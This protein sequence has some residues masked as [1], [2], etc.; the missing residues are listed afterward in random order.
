MLYRRRMLGEEAWGQMSRASGCLAYY[1]IDKHSRFFVKFSPHLSVRVLSTTPSRFVGNEWSLAGEPHIVHMR[2]LRFQWAWNFCE[3]NVLATFLKQERA[4][5]NGMNEKSHKCK[6]Q[7]CLQKQ[8]EQR[9]TSLA[10]E[11]MSNEGCKNEVFNSAVKHENVLSKVVAGWRNK[12]GST[13]R[14]QS[15]TAVRG[16]PVDASVKQP[17]KSSQA[18]GSKRRY[19]HRHANAD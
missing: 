13:E 10:C 8:W 15:S 16:V 1:Y 6:R 14:S 17:N 3:Y 19:A 11:K 9:R 12:P 4:T 18:A 5:M 2:T 7:R